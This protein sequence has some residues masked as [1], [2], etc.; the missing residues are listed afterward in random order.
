MTATTRLTPLFRAIVI[1]L[2]TPAACGTTPDAPDGGDASAGDADATLSDS[3]PF[4]E[5]S[6]IDN[7]V[8]WCDAG[9]PQ[10]LT[11][12]GCI[13]Y[14]YVPCGLPSDNHIVDPDSGKLNQCNP[15]CS[16]VSAQ[17]C[18]VVP[19][20]LATDAGDDAGDAGI[21]DGAVYVR[22]NCGLGGRRPAGLLPPSIRARGALATYFSDMSHLEAASVPAF[23]RMHAELQT[24]EAPRRLLARVRRA[25]RDEKRH[26]RVVGAL[27]GR[28]GGARPAVRI[29]GFRARSVVAMACENAAEGCVRETFGALVAT[30]QAEHAADVGIRRAM[31]RIAEDETRHAELSW[32]VARFLDR[33][34]GKA[35]RRRVERSRHRAMMNLRAAMSEPHKHL[36]TR[37]GMPDARTTGRMLD[38]LTILTERG[39]FLTERGAFLTE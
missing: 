37:A 6:T 31:T 4:P 14:F 3:N 20:P 32:D 39:A 28:F 13:S 21:P 25:V 5:G 18:E 23:E 12:D 24:L 10:V 27:A 1:A 11:N 7:Y 22:C 35:A 34:L 19:N 2:S 9:P 38:A 8:V 17:D 16:H 29:R 30:W 36:L 33:R 15:I 26:A